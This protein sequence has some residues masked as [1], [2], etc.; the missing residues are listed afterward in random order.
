VTCFLQQI[1][2][3]AP[4]NPEIFTLQQAISAGHL[5][6]VVSTS[7]I[8][9]AVEINAP[10]LSKL[11]IPAHAATKLLIAGLSTAIFRGKVKG[12]LHADT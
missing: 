3:R 2:N 6:Q 9:N 11:N 8:L 10:K 4:I 12:E 7:D 5:V 1:Q